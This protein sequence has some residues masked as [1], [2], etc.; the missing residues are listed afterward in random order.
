MTIGT[1]VDDTGVVEVFLSFGTV[2]GLCA[3]FVMSPLDVAVLLFVYCSDLLFIAASLLLLVATLLL[4]V[5][6]STLPLPLSSA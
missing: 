1:F 4:L 2:H 6:L 3:V 5:L